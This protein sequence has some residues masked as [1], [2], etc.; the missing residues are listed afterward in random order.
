M[1]FIRHNSDN[2]T[3]IDCCICDDAAGRQQLAEIKA[4]SDAKGNRRFIST[5]PDED[6]LLG[7]E[8][9]DAQI[10]VS[11]FYVV[12]NAATKDDPSD[13]F[14]HYCKLRDDPKKASP[15]SRGVTRK[16]LNEPDDKRGSSGIH[17][18]WPDINDADFKLELAHAQDGLSPNNLSPIIRYFVDDC[19]SAM[20][21]GDL[22]DWFLGLIVDK[23]KLPQTDILFAPHHGRGSAEVPTEMLKQISPRIIVIGE[24]PSEHLHYYDGYNTITQNSAGDIRFDIW[25]KDLH[26]F[27]SNPNYRARFLLNKNMTLRGMHY[28]GSWTLP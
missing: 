10:G 1:F 6:H 4:E 16:W 18:L 7:L 9:L 24:A 2:F 19:W 3:L 12:K 20:W 26:V 8:T 15:I 17:F 25:D 23:I 13:S 27:C 28:L 14:K 22:E 21:M 5:H 11:N